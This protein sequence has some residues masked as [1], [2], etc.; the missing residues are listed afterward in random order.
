MTRVA[1]QAAAAP[2]VAP[3]RTTSEHSSRRLVVGTTQVLASQVVLAAI[4]L[5]TLPVLGR[6]LGSALYGDFSLFVMLLGVVTYQDVARQLLIHAQANKDAGEEQLDALARLS[7]TA[8]VALALGAGLFVLEPLTAVALAGA[9]LLH[10]ISSRDYATLAVDGNVG[11]ASAIRNFAWAC[12]FASVAGLAFVSKSP[13]AYAAPFVVANALIALSYR[14]LAGPRAKVAS[15]CGPWWARASGWAQLQHAE[16]WPKWRS[17]ASD[18]L[19][20]TL[21]SSVIVVADRVLLDK[22]V[23]G[24]E[25]GLYCGAA[26]LVLRVH[27]VS[28]ALAAALYPSLA[29]LLH[30]RGYAF[31]AQH[32]VRVA[33]WIV[34]AYFLGLAALLCLDRAALTT[35]LGPAFAAAQPVF[36]LLVVGSFVHALGFLLTPWQ[37]AQGDFDSQRR[38]YTNAA[39]AMVAVGTVLVP[40]YGAIGAACAYLVARSIRLAERRAHT[41]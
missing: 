37:R 13:L 36:V 23:G 3:L 31:A 18:L 4:G 30:D 6:Q 16:Q 24:D 32:F 10:G 17:K 28:S 1:F 22:T 14:T 25:L 27:V 33:T 5:A 35:F 29:S 12:A 40:L 21:A 7:T 39:V 41:R 38:A 2:V 11:A 34:C 15:S 9:A 26:D 19:G 8:I 20:F